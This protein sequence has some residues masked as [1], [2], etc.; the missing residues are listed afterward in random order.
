[1]TQGSTVRLHWQPG[2]GKLPKGYLLEA[3]TAPGVW[4]LFTLPLG[5]VGGM[6]AT[7]AAGSYAVRLTA[8][9]ECGASVW[10]AERAVKIKVGR[11]DQSE[12]PT[13]SPTW[14]APQQEN[15]QLTLF[16]EPPAD[17]GIT[18]YLIEATTPF[19]PF[20]YDTSSPLTAL[21]HVKPA[22]GQYI[23]TVRAGN[24]AGFGPPSNPIT[25]IVE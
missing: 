4:D 22:P 10:G 6:M 12:R 23:V 24:D 14:L 17:D 3:G 7:A 20:T 1:V 25:L 15:D 16:W 19:G 13:E 5:A 11:G 2:V 8:I 18:R 9:N 21:G